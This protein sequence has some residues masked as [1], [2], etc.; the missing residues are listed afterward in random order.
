MN[1]LMERYIDLLVKYRMRI[2]LIGARSREDIAGIVEDSRVELADG[3]RV[4]D[5]GSGAGIPGLP[6][7]ILNPSIAISFMDKNRKKMNVLRLITDM[8]AVEYDEILI[9]D[10]MHFCDTH[11]QRFD[12]VL[13]RGVGE[14]SFVGALARPFLK[15][16]GTLYLWKP[17]GYDPGEG[18]NDAG[19][20]GCAGI[21][22]RKSCDIAAFRAL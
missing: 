6:A 18:L 1:E 20:D 21:F 22:H 4:L 7:K 14:S 8:L 13:S 12:A 16:G 10:A 11:G 9:G 19:Y 5:L 3:M 2:N 15:S 17:R